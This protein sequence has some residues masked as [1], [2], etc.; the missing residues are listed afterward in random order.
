MIWA[1]AV[2]RTINCP[3][4]HEPRVT[5]AAEGVKLRC[6]C[7]A[8]FRAPAVGGDTPG[9]T[10]TPSTP[11]PAAEPVV[12]QPA[13]TPTPTKKS[14][15]RGV[16]VRRADGVT[17]KRAKPAPAKKTAATQQRAAGEPEGDPA[18]DAPVA[19]TRKTPAVTKKRRPPAKKAAPAPTVVSPGRG[20]V[21]F[22]RD[23]VR[24]AG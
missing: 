10:D 12:E 6:S 7:G 11:A 21:G 3:R 14:A 4:C 23:R 2:L 20:G 16:T 1:M 18:G 17:V 9:T 15:P 13:P 24:R 8:G 22:Y 5:K 19:P